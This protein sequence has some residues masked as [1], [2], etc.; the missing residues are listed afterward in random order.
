MERHQ[1]MAG[2]SVVLARTA[3]LP[4]ARF[5]VFHCAGS[6]VDDWLEIVMAEDCVSAWSSPTSA[7]I[8]LAVW[9][10]CS[11][12]NGPAKAPKPEALPKLV[13]VTVLSVVVWPA[14]VDHDGSLEPEVPA[15]EQIKITLLVTP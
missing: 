7:A 11:L 4:A 15:V 9:A 13:H 3:P 2:R 10:L 12:S 14:V 1:Q 8:Q 6:V 5:N